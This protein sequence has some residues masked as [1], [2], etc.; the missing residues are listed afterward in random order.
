MMKNMFLII[1]FMMILITF[2]Q[3]NPPID[4]KIK[5]AIAFGNT[6]SLKGTIKITDSIIEINAKGSELQRLKVK[7][8]SKDAYGWVYMG[9][10]PNFSQ[11]DIRYILIE[12]TTSKKKKNKYLLKCDSKDKF[13]N[14]VVSVIYTL[15]SEL[16]E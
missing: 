14:E 7:F 5:N 2:G 15:E 4:Y 1:A 3:D 10:D 16:N 8:I 9:I 11:A 6:L 12:D 13:T